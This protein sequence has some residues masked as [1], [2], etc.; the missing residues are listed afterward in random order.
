[1]KDDMKRLLPLLLLLAAGA[2]YAQTYP[3][4]PTIITTKQPGWT[5]VW[6]WVAPTQNVDGSAITGTLTYDVWESYGG[7]FTELA[8]GVSGDS[9]SQ[10]DLIAGVPCIYV[11]AD[12]SGADTIP[13]PPSAV[14]CIKVA[15]PATQPKPAT[16]VSAY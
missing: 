2:A 15:F 12:E 8:A 9:F 3:A 14:A 6:T 13:S 5:V 7:I 10:P 16:K 4:S 11:V 1:M